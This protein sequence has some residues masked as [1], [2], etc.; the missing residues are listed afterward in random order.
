MQD[1]LREVEDN[2]DP[3]VTQH[4]DN[5]KKAAAAYRAKRQKR[6]ATI[7]YYTLRI[8]G[9]AVVVAFFFYPIVSKLYQSILTKIEVG[10]VNAVLEGERAQSVVLSHQLRQLR[11]EKERQ[12]EQVKSAVELSV[13]AQTAHR[14]AQQKLHNDQVKAER[15]KHRALFEKS[16]IRTFKAYKGNHVI[17]SA[18]IKGIPWEQKQEKDG[19]L[20]FGAYSPQ[21]LYICYYG[22]VDYYTVAPEETSK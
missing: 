9:G 1:I 8:V 12:I 14:T 20:V 5:E 3:E 6:Y 22:K 19:F 13:A 16:M 4:L 2:F 7:G 15:V 21:G 11:L 18:K 10:R 17:F